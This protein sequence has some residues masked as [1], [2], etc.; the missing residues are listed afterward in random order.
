M[1]G[2]K[3]SPRTD[4]TPIKAKAPPSP[5]DMNKEK[6][7]DEQ[8][9]PLMAQIIAICRAN[10]IAFV[11]SFHVPNEEDPDLHCT[12]AATTEEYEPSENLKAAVR[13]ILNRPQFAAFTVTRP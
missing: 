9:N 8:V 2:L 7:Y 13:A 11:A 10:K 1:P 4:P 12:S 3:T 6:I 5:K